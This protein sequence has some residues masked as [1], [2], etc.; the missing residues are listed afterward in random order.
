M[1]QPPKLLL[2]GVPELHA[3]SAVFFSAERRFQLLVVLA[4]Q[5]GRWVERDRIAALLWPERGLAEGRRNLRKVLFKAH[6]IANDIEAKGTALR[7][8]V[9][10]DVQAF[11]E[12]RRAGRLD[13]ALAR[14]RAEPLLGMDDPANAALLSWF[15]AERARMEQDWQASA[16]DH[17]LAQIEPQA[18]IDAARLWLAVDPFAEPA[19]AALLKAERERGQHAQ[20]R[21]AY[22]RYAE[23]LAEELG[24][25]P[26]RALRDLVDEAAPAAAPTR[27]SRPSSAPL[28]E[29]GFI[30]RKAELQEL[31]ALLNRPECQMVT[32][33][34]PGGIGKSSLA[35]RALEAAVVRYPGGGHWV[36]L[37]DLQSVAQCVARLARQLGVELGETQ[38][39]VDPLARCLDHAPT[40]LV[41]DNAEHLSEL[42]AL[43]QSLLSAAPSLRVL[44]TSRE[45]LRQ[46]P[47]W[48]LPL[49]GLAVPDEDSRDLE[50]AG[51]FDAVRLFEDRA[52]AAQRSFALADH[53]QAVI[54]IVEA[55][56]GM[57]L[58]I[59]LAASWVRL[60]PPAEIARELRESMDLLERDLAGTHEPA[61][62]EHRSV[63]AVLERSWR[64]LAPRERVGLAGLSVFRGGFTRLGAQRVAELSLPLLSSLVDKSLVAVDE[65]GRFGLHPL[66]AAYAATEL[67]ADSEHERQVRQRHAEFFAL[68]LAALAAHAYGDQRLLVAGVAAEAA[69]CRA[70][71]ISVLDLQRV[72]LVY[73]MSRTLCCDFELRGRYTEGIELMSP[74]LALPQRHAAAPR[75]LTALRY[76]LS[77]LCHRKG[78]QQQ[79]MAL[80][81]SGIESGKDCGDTGAYVGC[82]LNTGMCLWMLGRLDEARGFHERGLQVARERDD[83]HSVVWALGNLAVCLLGLGRADEARAMTEQALA[84]ARELGDLYYTAICL[85]NLGRMAQDR[86]DWDAATRCYEDAI[87]HCQQ[88]GLEAIS[89][90]LQS[91]LGKLLHQRGQPE[92]A[93]V[94]AQAALARARVTGL[95]LVEWAAEMV[96]AGIALEQAEH[97]SAWRHLRN[98]VVSARRSASRG[99]VAQAVER[100]GDLMAATGQ[101]ARAAAIWRAARDQGVL[102]AQRLA[103]IASKLAAQT[104][105]EKR[106]A[107]KPEA[108][109]DEAA[110]AQDVD[111]DELLAQIERGPAGAAA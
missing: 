39:P 94:H 43:L 87:S 23:Q 85:N 50:A 99:H 101:S 33:V 11:D 80:A 53:L 21:A 111:F 98:I 9:A 49:Q 71:W 56:G 46:A 66:V 88:H 45:R 25:E 5:A 8:S 97:A 18:R 82:M 24:V 60:L 73:A 12:D 44:V 29:A 84:G 68:M 55:V 54:N 96:L 17:L 91:N 41:L 70:A 103:A 34:G 83:P 19:L 63:N 62:P 4:L 67:R 64:L 81:H 36:E 59:E 86:Q 107:E 100:F 102:D 10:T 6:E 105:A 92:R 1:H 77:M 47:G 106:E 75:A 22:R 109:Q 74:A 108:V 72:D 48:L 89:V 28:V 20:A 69:N 15:A 51:S 65:Q 90:Y 16:L 58:A 110:R 93:R 27:P 2:W 95:Q 35:R 42:P 57:P 79:A 76:G 3:G 14:R 52:V 7:W 78:D 13:C 30:G 26:S 31:A 38:D 40:L 61:R 104:E 32:I 37:Q